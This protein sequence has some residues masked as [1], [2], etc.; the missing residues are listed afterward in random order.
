MS[1]PLIVFISAEERDALRNGGVLPP[2]LFCDFGGSTSDWNLNKSCIKLWTNELCYDVGCGSD[3]PPHPASLLGL[4]ASNQSL[5]ANE[6]LVAKFFGAQILHIVFLNCEKFTE[7]ISGDRKQ[8]ERFVSVD[9][10]LKTANWAKAFNESVKYW[11]GEEQSRGINHA[12]LVVAKDGRVR[13]SPEKRD[14]LLK[15]FSDEGTLNTCYFLDFRLEVETGNDALHSKHLWPVLA[16]RLIL[17]LLIALSED[18][19]D[20]LL[21]P[22][23]HLWRSFEFL[24]DYPVKEMAGMLTQALHKAYHRLSENADVSK[25]ETCSF[26]NEVDEASIFP[27]IPRSL[28][29]FNKVESIKQIEDNQRR[30]GEKNGEIDWHSYHSSIIVDKF[31]NNDEERWGES[32]DKARIDFNEREAKLFING[33]SVSKDFS[34]Y[35]IFTK[36]SSDPN[37]VSF[38]HKLLEENR[39]QD[40]IL[41]KE[42]HHN[43]KK[44]IEKENERKTM[45]NNLRQAGDELY[46]AQAHYVTVPYAVAAVIAVSLFCG[47]TLFLVLNSIGIFFLISL[48][49]SAL[50][51]AGAFSAWG[52]I[53]YFHRR[54]GKKAVEEFKD[55]ASKVDEAMD[56]RHEAAVNAIRE[57]EFQHRKILRRDS[58][59]SLNRL[60]ERVWRILSRELQSP[61]LSAFYRNEKEVTNQEALSPEEFETIHQYELFLEKTR[62]VESL[63]E[64]ILSSEHHRYSDYVLSKALENDNG[65]DSF[66]SFWR[67][68]YSSLDDRFQGNLPANIIIP[69]I[70]NWLLELCNKLSA[71]QK[72]DLLISRR[73]NILPNGF[74][75]IRW[76]TDYIFASAHVDEDQVYCSHANVYVYDDTEVKEGSVRRE[77]IANSAET[78]I[79]GVFQDIPVTVTP[80]LNGLPQIAVY[81]Q[82]I[83][84]YGFDCEE[85]GRLKF[86]TKYKAETLK[87]ALKGEKNE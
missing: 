67:R 27:E 20:D 71:A 49:F 1:K 30:N 4:K 2:F 83:R 56:A 19:N 65:P 39:P 77:A 7:Q 29:S 66:Y 14:L 86:L 44:V 42:I 59:E 52:I 35:A 78:I 46:L 75:I 60:L 36:V 63:H 47:L 45:Q 34:P 51:V 53:S 10:I 3:I 41:K 31:A 25:A 21:L 55:I 85:D 48:L 72:T 15:E 33:N 8:D 43:W 70:R 11:F 24:F 84:I 76:D 17:R 26:G 5:F 57:A 81:F 12:V 9:K 69:E 54:A 87:A 6:K 68:I 22:G 62:F 13:L 32:L 23:V 18:V 50:S 58:W 38:Y 64:E 16:G 82:D 79:Q 80:I 61:T 28:T 74:E 37:M 73:D 40:S